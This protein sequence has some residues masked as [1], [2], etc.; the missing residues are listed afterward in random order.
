MIKR[1]EAFSGLDCNGG[2]SPILAVKSIRARKAV[3]H[4]TQAFSLTSLNF[5]N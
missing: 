1:K 5:E 4:I 2:R 3:L